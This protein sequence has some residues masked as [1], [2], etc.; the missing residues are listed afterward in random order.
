[1]HFDV[2]SDNILFRRDSG[3]A[4]FLDWNWLHVGSALIDVAFFAV[5]VAEGCGPLPQDIVAEYEVHAGTEFSDDEVTTCAV[6]VARDSSRRARIARNAACPRLRWVQRLQL[7]PALEWAQER[8][9]LP[10]IP[11]V[12]I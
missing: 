5:G 6:G 10:A 4:V 11:Q 3:Q 12:R 7:F 9:G 2:R 8:L 1:M